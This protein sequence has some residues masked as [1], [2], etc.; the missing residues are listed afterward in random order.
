MNS[1]APA[2]IETEILKQMAPEV[3][4]AIVAKSPMKR[5]GTTDEVAEIVLWLC[6]EA[7]SFRHGSGVRPIWWPR[8]LLTFDE[9]EGSCMPKL[10]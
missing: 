4:E 5:L 8:D 3:V 6:S 10:N 7:C 2:A 1:L 9:S